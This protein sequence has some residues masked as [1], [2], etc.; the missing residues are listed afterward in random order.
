MIETVEGKNAGDV[1]LYG[2]STCMWCKKTKK[3]LDEMG[4]KY[5]YVFVDLLDDE[6]KKHYH[7]EMKVWNPRGSFPTLVI[8]DRKTII[9]YDEARIREALQ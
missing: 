1:M 7:E 9:G 5:T 3:L 8:N 6:M 4:I 2:L